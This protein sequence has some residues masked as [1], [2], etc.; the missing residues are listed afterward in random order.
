M[1]IEAPTTAEI[2]QIGIILAAASYGSVEVIKAALAPLRAKYPK[3]CDRWWYN[4][5][6]RLSA[7]G[8]GAIIGYVLWPTWGWAVGL[9]CG[10]LNSTIVAAIKAKIKK[11]K[12]S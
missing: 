3:K 8:S 10:G 11:Q 12:L 2:F 1:G 7:V 4:L 9:G 6:I 5:S